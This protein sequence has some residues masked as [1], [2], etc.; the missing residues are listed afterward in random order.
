MC[1]NP[2]CQPLAFLIE[3]PLWPPRTNR[4]QAAGDRSAPHHLRTGSKSSGRDAAS[5]NRLRPLP[6]RALSWPCPSALAVP[7]PA[8]ARRGP[9]VACAPPLAGPAPSSGSLRSEKG[10]V[11][12]S[13]GDGGPAVQ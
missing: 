11:E 6:E 8:V 9:D 4:S 5:L 3:A 12:V 7:Y 13:V 2:S 1:S 10:S